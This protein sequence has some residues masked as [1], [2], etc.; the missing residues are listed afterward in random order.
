MNVLNFFGFKYKAELDVGHVP[1]TKLFV[2]KG[3]TGKVSVAN[4]GN[5]SGYILGGCYY[6]FQKPS[7]KKE[8]Q[9]QF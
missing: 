6:I 8:H 5:G 7:E 9:I 1:A 4:V 3:K 2:R